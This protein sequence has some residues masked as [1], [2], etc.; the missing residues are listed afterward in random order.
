MGCAPALNRIFSW[1][2]KW[3][4]APDK[5]AIV[6]FTR[7][8]KPGA[9]PLLFLNGH[10]IRSHPNFKFLGVWFDQ[11]LLWKTHIEH[12]HKQCLNLKRLFTVVANARYGPPVDTL[13]LLYKSLVRSKS[14]YGLIAYG[15]ASKSNLEKI[16]VVSR[17]IIRTILG[18]KLSTPKEVLYAESGTES[19]AER[20]DWL[21][22]KYVLNLGHKPHNPMSAPCL[23]ETMRKLKRLEFDT[24]PEVALFPSRHKHPAPSRPPKCITKWFP[25]SKKTASIDPEKTA[26][27][28]NILL[29]KQVDSILIAYTDGSVSTDTNTATC[30]MAIPALNIAKAWTLAKHS[31]IFSAELQAIKQCLQMIYNSDQSY[32]GVKI[33]CDSSPAILVI[34]SSNPSENEAISEIRE[35]MDSLL[36]SGT[37]TTLIWIPSHC[38]IA[39]NE[40]VDKLAVNQQANETDN[41][42]SNK[43]SPSEKISMFRKS[44]AQNFLAT[45]KHCRKPCI[46]MKSSLRTV[47][48]HQH[49]DRKIAICLHR[50]RSGHHYLNAFNHRINM[51][52]DPSC[53]YGCNVI[54][55]PR[56]ILVE[57]P[58]NERARQK[59]RQLFNNKKLVLNFETLLGL[60]TKL[61]T[62]TQF[63]IRN[64]LATFLKQTGLTSIV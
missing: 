57:C 48:W 51:E 31:S 56:N 10:R 20:R 23:S 49:K 61:D 22:S 7:S 13:T 59:M 12:V 24:F 19:L 64:E 52:A 34:K 15:N 62:R 39:G 50:L 6:A 58:K 40:Q 36:S 14:D 4:F 33:F 63:L 3:K 37:L 42:I 54:E 27:F 9:D 46:L 18:S 1:S 11:K 17:A 25:L 45:L 32:P 29:Q 60:N 47:K 38:G 44:W 41:K 16:N 21:S 8:Y 53:R 5:S 55:D 28:F 30:A 35:L 43:L 2:R 26:S